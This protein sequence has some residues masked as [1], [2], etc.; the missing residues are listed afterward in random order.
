MKN[1]SVRISQNTH[2]LLIELKGQLEKESKQLI[3]LDKTIEFATKSAKKE[4]KN[5]KSQLVLE[6]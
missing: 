4:L 2:K 3:S 1:T 6:L 5:K